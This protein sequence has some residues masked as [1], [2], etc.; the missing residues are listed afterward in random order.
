MRLLYIIPSEGFGGAERQAVYHIRHL[1]K[2]GIDVIALVGPGKLI[3]D[4]L[5]REGVKRVEFTTAML[6][7]FGKPPVNPVSIMKYIAVT[8]ITWIRAQK[9]VVDII[10]RHGVD[11]VFISRSMG[12]FMA[13][14]ASHRAGV[15]QIWRAGSCLPGQIPRLLLRWYAM[16]VCPDGIV[17]NCRA[18][19]SSLKSLIN[20]PGWIVYNGVDMGRFSPTNEIPEIRRKLHIAESTTVVGVSARPAP[21]KGLETIAKALELLNQPPAKFQI[22]IAGDYGWRGYFERLFADNGFS[23]QVRF[24]GYVDRIESFLRSCDIVILPSER[25]SME[26]LPNALLEAMAMQRPVIGTRVGGIA[27]AIKHN[28]TGLLVKPDDPRELAGALYRLQKSP[29]LCAK[30]GRQARKD[31]QKRFSLEVTVKQ[32]AEVLSQASVYSLSDPGKCDKGTDKNRKTKRSVFKRG[33]K[34]GRSG[35]ALLRRVPHVPYTTEHQPDRQEK[36]YR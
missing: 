27:E 13:G 23:Q 30:L 6:Q 36:T 2:W 10:R 9:V 26:G 15:L 19:R 16:L 8:S 7:D 20:A 14:I 32:I 34:S 21:G 11:C 33:A 29:Q 31:I 18:V 25:F 17:F 24:I 12:W 4:Q 22:V 5:A 35:F 1:K 28:E 3:L